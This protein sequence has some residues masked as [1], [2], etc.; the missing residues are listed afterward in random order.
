MVT[1]PAGFGAK[2]E[3]R[4]TSAHPM[5]L[6]AFAEGLELARVDYAGP[7][8]HVF[9]APVAEGFAGEV[10]FTVEPGLQAA[11]DVRDLGVLV[12]LWRDGA[13]ASGSPVEI[14]Y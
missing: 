14:V 11:G 2:L 13:G 7:G 5:T 12:T 8:E 10:R 6:A 1:E 9:V 3:F 4:F